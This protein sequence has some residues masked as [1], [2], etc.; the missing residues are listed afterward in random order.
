[1]SVLVIRQP[2]VMKLVRQVI[3]GPPGPPGPN[4]VT[5][6]TT[7]TLVGPLVGVGGYVT[8]ATG[9]SY[10]TD[11]TRWRVTAQ[12]VTEVP[13]LVRAATGQAA[14]LQKWLARD[15]VTVA[16]ITRD[17]EFSRPTPDM[18]N[19]ESFG[20]GAQAAG[21]A[22]TAL[23]AGARASGTNSSA[24]GA[25]AQAA[26]EASTALGV[27]AQASTRATATGQAARASGH[28]SSAYGQ[29]ARASGSASVA[30]GQNAHAAA[31]NTV[32]CGAG[33]STSTT[34]GSSIAIGHGSSASGPF[35][36][37][38]GSSASGSGV[39]IGDY[40]SGGNGIAIGR[41]S[42][43]PAGGIA[44]GPLARAQDHGFCEV[45][46]ASD[47]SSETGALVMRAASSDMFNNPQRQWG[48]HGSWVDNTLTNRRGRMRIGAYKGDTFVE[49]LRV[50]AS[51]AHTP[52]LSFFGAPAVERPVVTGSRGGNAALGSLISALA[53]LGLI[54][55]NT[56]P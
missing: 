47:G 42:A 49:S 21:E 20:A 53:Q 27:S 31:G 38:I 22:S 48:L 29:Y 18:G 36:V 52:L 33:A 23:G 30:I 37:I 24:L 39:V 45:C 4:Q 28:Y 35:S 46:P 2:S 40:A 41:Q 54:I 56:T 44:L 7:T 10:A 14:D 26:G 50:E 9:V 3:P 11:G 6:S 19:S 5:G 43:A 32:V 13:L 12:S 17:G 55:D 34:A 1:M 16:R 25:G 15:G 51:L 8:A